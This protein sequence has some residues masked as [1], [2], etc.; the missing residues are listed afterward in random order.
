MKGECHTPKRTSLRRI[1]RA[2]EGLAPDLDAFRAASELRKRLPPPLAREAAELYELRRRAVGRYPG[3]TG[4]NGLFT[5]KG[6]EQ[7]SR[8]PVARAKFEDVAAHA[9]LAECKRSQRATR[10]V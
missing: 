9:A 1:A 2:L 5:R 3:A 6:L 10:L 8:A 7:M 4:S